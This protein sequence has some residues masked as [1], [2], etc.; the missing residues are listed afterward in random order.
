MLSAE[1]YESDSPLVTILFAISDTGQGMTA[2][3]VRV[4]GE[5]YFRFN[6]E[7]NRKT[8]GTGLGMNI[9]RNLIQLMNGDIEVESTPGMGSTFT[10]RLPQKYEGSPPIGKDLADNLMKLN[11]KNTSKMRNMQITQDLMPYGSV[12]VVDDVETNLYVAKG[13]MAPYGLAIETALSGFEAV[14]KVRE[15]KVYDIIFMDHMMPRMDGIEAVKLIR[16]LGYSYPIVALTANALA[17]QEEVFLSNGFDDFISKPIDIRQL[18]ASLN[19]LIRDKQPPEVIEEM[20]RKKEK[21]DSGG[22]PSPADSNVTEFFIRDAEKAARVLEAISM[23]K[24]RR[25]DDISLLIIN[26]HAMKSALA[27]IGETELS[28]AAA[29]IEKAGRD[30]DIDFILSEIPVFLESLHAIIGKF[31]LKEDDLAG[32]VEISD[33]D[34]AYLSGKFLVLQTACEAYD[35]KAAK[36]VLTELRQRGWP[37]PIKESLDG[38]SERLLHSEFDEAAALAKSITLP[39]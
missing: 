13:R 6:V 34:R 32:D 7:A 28:G 3:Q 30:R 10:V 27:N 33:A 1:P 2:E 4:L 17:G 8:E 26:V 20:R 29:K 16:S 25:G 38:I 22:H 14:D 19:K 18:N 5:K 21:N 9:T 12:L 23:N 24:C 39:T 35:K 11:V 15:G 36:E 37:Q 31:K